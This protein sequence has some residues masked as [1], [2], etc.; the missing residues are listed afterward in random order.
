MI[1][2]SAKPNARYLSALLKQHNCT[3]VVIAPGSRNAP[4]IIAF[5]EDDEYNC[6]SVPD[7]RVTGF[8]A[9]GK[10]IAL[11]KPVAIFCSSGSASVNFHPAITEAYYQKLPLI[12]I[13]A[14]RPKEWIN[15]GIG[16]A[17]Q[18]ENIFEKH[19]VKSINLD[20]EPLDELTQNY[21]QRLINEAMLA[22]A[23]GPVHINV[24]FNEP[25]YN[26]VDSINENVRVIKTLS[27]KNELDRKDLRELGM[28]WNKAGKILVLAGQ[29]EKNEDLEKALNDLNRKSPFLIFSET[30][31][32]LNADRNV[33]AID[34]LINTLSDKD[35]ADLIPDLLITIGGDVVSKMVK[36]LLKKEGIKHWHISPY[37][38]VKDTFLNLEKVIPL[39]ATSFFKTLQ[40]VADEKSSSYADKWIALD[41]IK[42]KHH[43]DFVESIPYS[44]FKVLS[45]IY[46]A[47]PADGILHMANSTSVRYAQLFDHKE[48][49]KHYANRG[50]SGIDGCTSTAIG[51]AM[52]VNNMLTL[53]TGDVAFLYDSNAFWN[54][55]MPS[56]SRVIVINNGGGNIFRI[57]EG[58][59]KNDKFERFQETT[60]NLKVK[61]IVENFGIDYTLVDNENELGIALSDFYSATKGPKVLE[62]VTPRIES[63]EILK[64]Y[65][66]FIKE[67]S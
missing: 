46:D 27:A 26:T 7:E 30:V 43:L 13:T 20:R 63:P 12:V 64:K 42:S 31:S 39:E 51:H 44:D 53:I 6:I 19:M 54:D 59:D 40:T 37:K 14:D 17:I 21:N 24:A 52:H 15:Q 57:I 3:E 62:V 8:I 9:L 10:I 48:S 66:R 61:G 5:T 56:N 22:S 50:T 55:T 18:Q 36:S 34:R 1:K 47:L 11:K 65:F 49:I 38:E 29:M 16:Q 60:H 58:P 32:N 35:K 2:T 33:R 23:N 4:L 25:L 41:E 45:T 28:Q 67:R